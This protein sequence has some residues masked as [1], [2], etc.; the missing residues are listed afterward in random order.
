M[1]YGVILSRTKQSK[2]PSFRQ[3]NRLTWSNT[4][5]ANRVREAPLRAEVG[6]MIAENRGA[7]K[8][9]KES[10]KIIFRLLDRIFLALLGAYVFLGM[11]RVPFHGDESTLIRLSTDFAYIFQDRA[12][13]KVIYHPAT[14]YGLAEQYQRELTGSI[15]PLTIGMAWSAAGM[16][17]SDL[18]GFWL[19]SPP[20]VSDEW[21]F[22]VQMGNMPGTRLLDIARI[23]STL[24]TALSIA[25]VFV[26]ALGLSRS[27][28]AAWIAAFLYATTPSI[29]VNGRR[30]MQEGGL[31]LFTSLVVLGTLYILR[32]IR[33][34]KL[35]W[36]PDHSVVWIARAGKRSGTGQ[37]AHIRAG[38]RPR[39]FL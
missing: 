4:M 33:E 31:L 26:I 2:I 27:R 24:F 9:A 6:E 37:Q 3:K 18:N 22:N 32:L 25:V 17:R 20:G 36:Q 34:E 8:G 15:D 1:I 39:L 16:D 12:I 19:W 10:H 11:T 29:L 38:Y 23:P 14:G 28:P 5:S 21:A 35:R 13:Q 7:R 30:A